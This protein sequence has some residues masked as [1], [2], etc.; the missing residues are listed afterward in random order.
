MTANEVPTY[1]IHLCRNG[2]IFLTLPCMAET[3]PRPKRGITFDDP[4]ETWKV[5]E[6][7]SNSASEM[8]VEVESS[9]C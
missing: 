1:T 7:I 9:G 2:K 8:V 3:V 5:V 6:V 4:T